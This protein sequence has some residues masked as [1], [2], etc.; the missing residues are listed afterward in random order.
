LANLGAPFFAAAA[1]QRGRTPRPIAPAEEAFAEKPASPITAVRSPAG[2]GE[3][4]QPVDLAAELLSDGESAK[5]AA[6]KHNRQ[7]V[8]VHQDIARPQTTTG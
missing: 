4:G 1:Q 7:D 8:M 6:V 5:N 2:N 3:A